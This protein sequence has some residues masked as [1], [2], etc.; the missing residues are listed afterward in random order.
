MY[1]NSSLLAINCR[2][3]AYHAINDEKFDQDMDPV[4]LYRY[5]PNGIVAAEE[6]SLLDPQVMHHNFGKILAEVMRNSDFTLKALGYLYP[7]VV[8]R[9]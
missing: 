2:R 9:N 3:S 7:W 8:A 6:P 1:D 5:M 4:L